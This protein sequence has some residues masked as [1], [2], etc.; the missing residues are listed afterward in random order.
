MV[1]DVI[2]GMRHDFFAPLTSTDARCPGLNVIDGTHCTPEFLSGLTVDYYKLHLP[3]YRE[4]LR[5]SS[6]KMSMR[7]DCQ[8][9]TA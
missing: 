3:V 6:E 9:L 7:P 5:L 2:I 8:Q 1:G 4:L